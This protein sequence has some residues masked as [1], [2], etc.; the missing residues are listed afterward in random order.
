MTYKT[1]TAV[2]LIYDTYRTLST[3][4]TIA[5]KILNED[6]SKLADIT[7]TKS[8][9]HNSKVTLDYTFTSAGLYYVEIES[10]TQTLKL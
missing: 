4:D 8:A 5:G 1:N 2:T 10:N 7:L 6:L 3:G 9:N